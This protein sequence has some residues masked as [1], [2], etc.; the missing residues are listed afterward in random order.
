MRNQEQSMQNQGLVRRALWPCCKVLAPILSTGHSCNPLV[1][2]KSR[3]PNCEYWKQLGMYWPLKEYLYLSK[4]TVSGCP[5]ALPSGRREV[6]VVIKPSKPDFVTLLCLQTCTLVSEWLPHVAD[7]ARQCLVL[8]IPTETLW[9]PYPQEAPNAYM[10]THF[11]SWCPEGQ[12]CGVCWLESC[13]ENLS[14]R[15]RK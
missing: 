6:A 14:G 2:L 9:W 13:L 5:S 7:P 1:Q 10:W 12:C 3:L 15:L 11:L 8:G 4:Q